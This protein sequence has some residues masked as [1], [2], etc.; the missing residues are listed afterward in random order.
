[1]FP[2]R[3]TGIVCSTTCLPAAVAVTG[4]TLKPPGPV[5]HNVGC[6]AL[7][8]T[9]TAVSVCPASKAIVKLSVSLPV[10]IAADVDPS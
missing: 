1:M 10:P 2:P 9:T 7:A 3:S 5:T 4:P 8:G 6:K